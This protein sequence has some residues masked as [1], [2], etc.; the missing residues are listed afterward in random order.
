MASRPD[1]D[2]Q[3]DVPGGLTVHGQL[4]AAESLLQIFPHVDTPAAKLAAS[5]GRPSLGW[6]HPLDNAGEGPAPLPPAEWETSLVLAGR[7]VSEPVALF[8]DPSTRRLASRWLT[9]IRDAD[10]CLE[11]HEQLEESGRLLRVRAPPR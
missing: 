4:E 10:V 9:S 2:R 8:H 1:R 11:L 3:G 7:R 6:L 5:A